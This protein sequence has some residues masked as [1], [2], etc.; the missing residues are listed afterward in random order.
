MTEE[1]K[2]IIF[3]EFAQINQQTSR[4]YEG[5]GLGLGIARKLTERMN[6]RISIESRKGK[7]FVF[8]VTFPGIEYKLKLQEKL[9]G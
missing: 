9:D 7:G 2:E 4:Q 8:R 5:T 3:E 1:Q 6:G